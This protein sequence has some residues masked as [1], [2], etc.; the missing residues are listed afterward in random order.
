MPSALLTGQRACMLHMLLADPTTLG[1]ICSYRAL[2]G[3]QRI[4]QL[5]PPA[6]TM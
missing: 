5:F 6:V 4:E 2:Y 1:V 3:F